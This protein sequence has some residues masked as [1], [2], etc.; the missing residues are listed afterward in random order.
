[1]VEGVCKERGI[2]MVEEAYL[3]TYCKNTQTLEVVRM[4]SVAEELSNPNVDDLSMEF[5]DDESLIQW[6]LATRA[7]E[8]FRT[9]N[10]RYPGEGN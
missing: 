6:Y 7:S 8:Q 9:K 3:S 5:M 1:L 2:G 10:G 4:R